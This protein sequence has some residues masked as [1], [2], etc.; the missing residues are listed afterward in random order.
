[1]TMNRNE[2][3]SLLGN[4][5]MMDEAIASAMMAIEPCELSTRTVDELESRLTL[6]TAKYGTM[7]SHYEA[8]GA[9]DGEIHEIRLAIH[10]R[11]NEEIYNEFAD[12]ANVLIR[13]M[14]EM[15]KRGLV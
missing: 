12:A 2:I 8:I 1:M 5:P 15:E 14:Q 7:A 11:N 3:L 4:S 13:W 6:S 10:A 9:L